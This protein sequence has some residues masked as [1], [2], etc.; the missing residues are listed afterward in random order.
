M[1][2]AVLGLPAGLALFLALGIALAGF[3]WSPGPSRILA[4]AA[5]LTVSEWL[6]GHVLSGFP[7]NTFGYALTAP[8]R[9]RR[10]PH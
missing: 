6:R 3:L 4:L 5:A 7:W 1:P 10:A 8:C 9:W 2:F